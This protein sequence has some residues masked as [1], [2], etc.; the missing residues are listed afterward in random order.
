LRARAGSGQIAL[1]KARG[2]ALPAHDPHRWPGISM[3]M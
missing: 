3:A 2:A 1:W